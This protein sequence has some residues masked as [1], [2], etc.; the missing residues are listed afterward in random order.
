MAATTLRDRRREQLRDQI[1]LAALP[2]F[3]ARGFDAV[4]MDEIA[5]AAGISLSTLFR[6]ISSKDDL[7]A[8]SVRP[9]GAMIVANFEH[10]PATEPVRRALA[11]AILRRIEDFGGQSRTVRLWRQ[12][13][14][15]APPRVRRAAL[16][17]DDE[18]RSLV[19]LVAARLAP[20]PELEAG[21]LVHMMLAAA[22]YAYGCWLDQPASP[23]LHELTRQA[24]QVAAGPDE[25][26]DAP[27]EL[28]GPGPD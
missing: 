19:A 12:A 6:H 5:E 11:R 15:S 20:R 13:M 8:G 16:L 22:E 28:A 7:L 21:V 17:D 2:L 3:A 27:G 10:S 26:A 14:A 23:G 9:G 25:L 18:R 24:L 4:T 1:V